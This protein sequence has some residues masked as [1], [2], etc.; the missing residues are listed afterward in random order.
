MESVFKGNKTSYLINGVPETQTKFKA[1][2]A[3]HIAPEDKLLVLG[4]LHYFATDMRW[5]A[6]R[7]V[8]LDV[9]AP[10]LSDA[11]IIKAHEE[12]APLGG[13]IGAMTTVDDM[14]RQAK[15][16]RRELNTELNEI[17]ARIDEA[18]RSKPDL[19]PESER[20]STA[21]LMKEKMKLVSELEGLKSNA[22]AAAIRTRIARAESQSRRSEGSIHKRQHVR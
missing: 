17:P 7:A 16:K 8:L 4:K 1:F 9:F 21:A 5:D 22:D 19:P 14:A 10:H 13:W 2:V 15:A 11:D 18:E 3:E 20:P 12:L 6:R